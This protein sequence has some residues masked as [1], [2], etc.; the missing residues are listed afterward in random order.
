MTYSF[1]TGGGAG[2]GAGTSCLASVFGS[3]EKDACG[4]AFFFFPAFFILM[5]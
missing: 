5:I 2:G 4:A 3:G 1:E